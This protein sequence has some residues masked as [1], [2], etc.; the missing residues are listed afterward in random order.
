MPFRC[1][2]AP[3]AAQVPSKKN[4]SI[5]MHFQFRDPSRAVVLAL[6]IALSALWLTRPL[7]AEESKAGWS[8]GI[9]LTLE[10]ATGLRGGVG[11]GDVGVFESAN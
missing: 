2:L 5:P 4:D 8:T 3:C 10:G 9:D 11:V 6:A 7:S 1:P